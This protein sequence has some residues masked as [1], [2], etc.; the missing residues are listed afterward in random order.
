MQVNFIDGV[1]SITTSPEYG[2]VI[3]WVNVNPTS[4]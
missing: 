4:I 1:A 2:V 3:A